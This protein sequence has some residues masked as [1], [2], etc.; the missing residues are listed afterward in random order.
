MSFPAHY[1]RPPEHPRGRRDGEGTRDR[2]LEVAAAHISSVGFHKM[3]IANVAKDAGVSQSGLLH[4]FRSKAALLSA[5]LEQRESED[6][7]FLFGDGD[8][9]LGW[10]AFDALVSLS[11]RNSTRP[12]MVQLFVR[13]SA[14]ATDPAHPAHDWLTRH[15]GGLRAWLSDA[16]DRG[17]AEGTMKEELPKDATI[18]TA[19]A[20]LDGLQQQWVSDSTAVAMTGAVRAHV[21]G[22]KTLWGLGPA[23]S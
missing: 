11:A 22:L 15:Y 19:I 2:L 20:V 12:E 16:I 18:A 17:I 4:H 13:I 23:S 3:S 6:N 9:P 8:V 14:E 5:V 1:E 7:L 21:R 10:D